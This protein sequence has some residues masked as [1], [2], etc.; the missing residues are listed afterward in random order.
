MGDKELCRRPSALRRFLKNRRG[1]I[2]TQFHEVTRGVINEV[3][4]TATK[5]DIERRRAEQ[6]ARFLEHLSSGT[7]TPEWKNFGYKHRREIT[8]FQR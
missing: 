5:K 7:L 6:V 3:F 2:G 1:K 4:P 8:I